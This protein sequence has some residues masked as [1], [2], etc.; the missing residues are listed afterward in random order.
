MQDRQENLLQKDLS[1]RSILVLHWSAFALVLLNFGAVQISTLAIYGLASALLLCI[2]VFVRG[3]PKAGEPAV[4]AA[5]VLALVAFAWV[6]F[7]T[8]PLPEAIFSQPSWRDL[9]KFQ[10]DASP[11]I[12]L[13]PADDWASLLRFLVPVEVFLIGIILC[14][15]DERAIATLRGLAI[16]GAVVALLSIAQFLIAPKTL[17]FIAKTTYLDSLTGFFVNRNT[18]ATY[19][20]IVAILNYGI[21]SN[22]L[23][24]VEVRRILTSLDQGRGL[25]FDQRKAVR[26]ALSFAILFMVSVT[27][28]VLTKSRAGVA[29]SFAA[30]LL[31]TL[32]FVLRS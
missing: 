17:L 25:P 16:A 6:M 22:H 29:A 9:A 4:K 21:L 18:A 11:V 24:C 23:R 7:Q 28:L 31:M 12:S 10:L 20:G 1:C 32:L 14:D 3:I 2:A 5:I 26:G 15:S 30:L 13:T 19:F 27:A 8:T